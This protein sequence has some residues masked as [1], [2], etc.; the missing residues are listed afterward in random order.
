[1]IGNQIITVAPGQ[2]VTGRNKIVEATG[3]NRSKIERLLKVL[4]NEHQIEQQTFTK[5]RIISITNWCKYQIDEQQ[6]EQQVSNKRATSE[7]K[8]EG[9]EGKEGKEKTLKTSSPESLHLSGLLATLILENNPDNIQLGN[10]KREATVNRW[11]KDIDKLL[12]LDGRSESEVE[13]T[14]RW[15]QKDSFWSANILSG[16]TLREKWDKLRAK[17]KTNPGNALS[18]QASRGAA[19]VLSMIERIRKEKPNV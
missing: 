11:A 7:H 17:M 9:K 8:Q 16:K 14:I 1:M 5:Y 18:I 13:E 15:C 3:L 12:K 19:N 6:S 10:G 2:I 4:E